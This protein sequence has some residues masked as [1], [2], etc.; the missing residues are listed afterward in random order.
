MKQKLLLFIAACILANIASLAQVNL[1]YKWESGTTYRF[2]ANQKDDITMS[3]M[4]M[5]MNDLFNTETVFSLKV[6]DVHP[7]GSAKAFFISNHSR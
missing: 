1:K 6:S 2:K 3:A 7:N 4:G 5:N